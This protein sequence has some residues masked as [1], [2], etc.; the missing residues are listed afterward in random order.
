MVSERRRAL[1]VEDE[2]LIAM[3]LEAY[4]E[5]LGYG[6][7][8]VAARLEDGMA[9]ARDAAV[10]VVILDVNLAGEVS[11]PIAEILQCR[12]IPFVFVTGYGT[13]GRPAEFGAVPVLA[14]P[15]GVDALA[16]CL[17]GICATEPMRPLRSGP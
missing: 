13:V 3:L 14:K 9:A 6:V 17:A 5:E 12:G 16:D 8:A 2:G 4:L 10:D 15:F 11:Y 7:S 1:I